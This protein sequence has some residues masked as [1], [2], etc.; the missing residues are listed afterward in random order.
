M[1]DLDLELQFANLQLNDV[2]KVL[3][4]TEAEK[5]SLI[6]EKSAILIKINESDMAVHALRAQIE[7][8]ES[9]KSQLQLKMS[10]L[11]HEIQYA[12]LQF[13][14]V[15]HAF[16]QTELEKNLLVEEKFNLLSKMSNLD[17]EIQFANLQLTDVRNALLQIEF[18][19]N[20]LFQGKSGF[21]R[22]MNEDGVVID[23]LKAQ[24][25][26]L[27]I[28]ESH[29]LQKISNLDLEIQSAKLQLINIKIALLTVEDEKKALI[30][31]NSVVESKLLEAEFM[32]EK[33]QAEMRELNHR[34][35]TLLSKIDETGKN[36]LLELRCTCE[37]GTLNKP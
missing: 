9:E 7:E 31:G 23:S 8:V 13:I 24:V 5:D 4:Q 17:H 26:E 19:R 27:E 33:L 32:K 18:E 25:K 35:S 14:D 28:E 2:R 15:K 37:Q 16:V 3:V 36:V 12:N 11:D 1:S 6:E 10:Q 22:K 21:L 30:S 29:F 34:N 20:S